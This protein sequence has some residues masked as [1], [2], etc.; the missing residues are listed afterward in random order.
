VT[1]TNTVPLCVTTNTRYSK[2]SKLAKTNF[3]FSRSTIQADKNDT[4]R[5]SREHVLQQTAR[6]EKPSPLI[7]VA[8]VASET[9]E[10]TSPFGYCAVLTPT[11]HTK[12]P[13]PAAHV[14][15]CTPGGVETSFPAGVWCVIK[16]IT[17]S[18]TATV[19]HSANRETAT[20]RPCGP[21]TSK[22]SPTEQPPDANL[23]ATAAKSARPRSSAAAGNNGRTPAEDAP[24]RRSS[25]R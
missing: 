22:G 6:T 12:Q 10:T 24:L 18:A 3:P 7:C 9:R 2:I 1:A 17:D 14:N 13:G 23:G 16:Q 5:T 8:A 19:Q 20:N 25:S 4:T 11:A 21:R 15:H